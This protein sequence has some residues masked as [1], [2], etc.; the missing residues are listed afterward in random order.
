VA[1]GSALFSVGP[2]EAVEHLRR[3]TP[4]STATA[5]AA[6]HVSRSS[7]TADVVDLVTM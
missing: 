6:D 2:L 1:G 3:G 4:G 7:S 5:L